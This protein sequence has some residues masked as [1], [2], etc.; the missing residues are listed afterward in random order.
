MYTPA[1][2]AVKRLEWFSLSKS[3]AN[4]LIVNY[5]AV[6]I[7]E[8]CKTETKLINLANHKPRRLNNP[9]KG[10]KTPASE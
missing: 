5:K 6:S 3:R 10:E 8:V 9:V 7:I 1:L 2:R 4:N